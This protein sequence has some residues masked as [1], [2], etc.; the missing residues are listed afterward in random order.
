MF[1]WYKHPKRSQEQ[2]GKEV[3]CWRQ[4]KENAAL[5]T[6]HPENFHR[7]LRNCRKRGSIQTEA[8]RRTLTQWNYHF[9]TK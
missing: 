8:V 7:F 5:S 4:C 6:E 2:N 3:V 9:K 1:S